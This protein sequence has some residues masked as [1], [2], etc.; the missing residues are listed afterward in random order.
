MSLGIL[1][2]RHAQGFG[3]SQ[4]LKALSLMLREITGH[5]FTS[6]LVEVRKMGLRGAL[7]LPRLFIQGPLES[8][9]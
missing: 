7:T 4:M 8:G 9:G 6:V 5:L 3:L 1:G 2:Q